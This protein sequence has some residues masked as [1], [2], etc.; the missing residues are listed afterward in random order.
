M[1]PLENTKMTAAVTPVRPERGYSNTKH[2]ASVVKHPKTLRRQIGFFYDANEV[3]N[4]HMRSVEL[5]NSHFGDR[6]YRKIFTHD[7]RRLLC[8]TNRTFSSRIFLCSSFF[9]LATVSRSAP[10]IRVSYCLS[11]CITNRRNCALTSNPVGTIW[12]F[13][14][15]CIIGKLMP[16][17]RYL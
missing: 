14:A 13:M 9:S 15:C 4:S 2:D 10:V 8:N 16:S 12:V 6:L 1:K 17:L 3:R 7:L 11:I 5:R